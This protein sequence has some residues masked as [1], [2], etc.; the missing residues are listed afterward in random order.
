MME[1]RARLYVALQALMI[2]AVWLSVLGIDRACAVVG[3][4]WRVSLTMAFASLFAGATGEGGGAIAF[5]VFTKILGIPA[6]QARVF[7]LAIQSIGMTAASLALI[8]GRVRIE[9]RAVAWAGLG[10]VAGMVAAA[11]LLA[12]LVPPPVVRVTFTM[13][14]VALGLVLV[15]QWRRG[16]SKAERLPPGGWEQRAVLVAAGLVGGVASA[17]IG[18]GLSIIGFSVLVVYF[19]LSE[20]AAIVTGV[21]LMALDSLAGFATYAALGAF[22]ATIRAYWLAA[23]PVAALSAPLGAVLGSMLAR[24]TIVCLVLTLIAVEFVTT[25]ALVPMDA[26]AMAYAATV[27]VASLLA[28]A[29]LARAGRA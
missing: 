21:V 23:L 24:R 27:F 6:T 17:L 4:N 5:P 13:S 25:V 28:Y 15:A 11:A 7:A 16:E 2:F 10:G 20:K 29:G 9:W 3:A 18:T 26:A 19:R 14:Q 8:Y 22:D 12:P 1:R